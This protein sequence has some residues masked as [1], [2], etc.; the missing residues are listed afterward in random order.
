M[1]VHDVICRSGTADQVFN[2]YISLMPAPDEDGRWSCWFP[3]ICIKFNVKAIPSA[4]DVRI[5]AMS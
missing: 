3:L 2:E 1:Y 5:P 4:V